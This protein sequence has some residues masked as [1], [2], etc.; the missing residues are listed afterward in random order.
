MRR[1]QGSFAEFHPW[2]LLCHP[3]G[4]FLCKEFR[5]RVIPTDGKADPTDE[6]FGFERLSFGPE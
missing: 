3:W 1:M 5:I 6:I 2:D 4:L